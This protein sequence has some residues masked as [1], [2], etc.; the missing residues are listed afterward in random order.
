MPPL[1][2]DPVVR[3]IEKP[4]TLDTALQTEMNHSA[5]IS[6]KRGRHPKL[7]AHDLTARPVDDH[8]KAKPLPSKNSYHRTTPYTDPDTYIMYG[9]LTE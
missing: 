8:A 9:C 4:T 5:E 2:K 7:T 6:G 3:L 1:G